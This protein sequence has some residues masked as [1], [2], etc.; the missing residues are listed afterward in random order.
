MVDE[1]THPAMLMVLDQ[2]LKQKKVWIISLASEEVHNH[3]HHY[4]EIKETIFFSHRD[5]EFNF[6]NSSAKGLKQ[7]NW[8]PVAFLEDVSPSILK[9]SSS[10]MH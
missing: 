5:I 10:Q 3:H 9:S 4:C 8:T 1:Q 6:L 7:G 2:G